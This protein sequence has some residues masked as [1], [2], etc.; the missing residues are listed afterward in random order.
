MGGRLALLAAS[1]VT[2]IAVLEIACRLEHSRS[3]L[4]HWPNLV[5]DHR[6]GAAR[7]IDQAMI[8][9]PELGYMPRPGYARAD[10]THDT[11]PDGSGV[12]RTPAPAGL[13]E[14][15]VLL[16]LGDSFTYGAEVGDADAWPSRLQALVGIRVLNAGVPA[17]GLDQIVLR[18]ERLARTVRPE[19]IIVAFIAGDV[20]RNELSR[21]AGFNKPYLIQEGNALAVAGPVPPQLPARQSLTLWE[22][23]FGWSALLDTVL[24]RLRWPEDWPADSVRVLPRGSGELMV[25]PLM[26]R[27]AALRIPVLVV[28][29]YDSEVW[30]DDARAA[31]EQRRQAAAVLRCAEQ[32]GLG[33]L[34][35]F[36]ALDAAGARRLFL[37]EGHLDAEGNT[38]TAKAIAAALR[39]MGLSLR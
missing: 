37:S 16:A 29:Q 4:V 15:P 1:I 27:L 23:L 7:Y 24:Q 13:P 11:A 30:E 17:Y 21:F 32:A 10:A 38:L 5:L 34:D 18:A 19:A 14:R 20:V 3:Y 25:C 8:H 39:G 12:R 33:T 2:A 22:D 6:E 31:A 36:A 26:Q 35:T 9:D 28:A